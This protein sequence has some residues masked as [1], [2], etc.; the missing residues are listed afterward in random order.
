M[1]A[2]W[3][4][5]DADGGELQRGPVSYRNEREAL[6]GIYKIEPDEH[7]E[8]PKLAPGRTYEVVL[9]AKSA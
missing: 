7:D 1:N 5:T 3:L 8:L 4:V 9:E 2:Y 6:L